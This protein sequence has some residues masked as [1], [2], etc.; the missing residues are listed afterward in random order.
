MIKRIICLLMMLALSCSLLTGCS[1]NKKETVEI[2]IKTPDLEMHPKN[3]SEVKK[4]ADFLEKAARAFEEQYKDFNVKINVVSFPLNEDTEYITDCF[5]TPDAADILFARY[6]NMSNYIYT[7]RVV[8]LDDIVNDDIKQDIEESNWDISKVRV[9]GMTYMI[10]YYSLQNILAYNKEIF[11][12]AGL[13]EYISSEDIIQNWT[14]EEWDYILSKLREYLPETSYPMMMYA[15][16]DEGDTHT[17]TVIRSQGSHFFD[18]NGLFALT[19]I[20]GISGLQWI[21]DNY[22]KGY[23]PKDCDSMELDDMMN[24][25]ANEQLGICTINNS[26]IDNFPEIDM[27]YVNFPDKDEEGIVT[28]YLTGFEVFDNGS[29]SRIK[30]AKDFISFIYENHEWMEYS[31]AGIPVCSKI[32]DKYKDDIFMIEEFYNNNKNNVD[33]TANNP[34]WRGVRNVFFYHI[35]NLITGDSSPWKVAAALDADCNAMIKEGWEYSTL[36]K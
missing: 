32:K 17:M 29:E 22:D 4:S 16:N 24:M 6:L 13:E 34:N 2:T 26:I 9:S 36:H 30:V 3:D 8:P 27:G 1:G 20:E 15:K 10:P 31:S 14:L 11:R 33:F 28:S 18:E 12:Q 19:T 35:Q 23:Y 21:K 25:F 5:G 7:G